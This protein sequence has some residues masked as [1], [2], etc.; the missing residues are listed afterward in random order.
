[1]LSEWYNNGLAEAYI[2]FRQTQPE[3]LEVEEVKDE[4]EK[5]IKDR[6]KFEQFLDE[7]KD[8]PLSNIK[9]QTERY[10][11]GNWGAHQRHVDANSS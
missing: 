6:E 3:S 4:F 8:V 7:N 10:G 1:M 5:L 2:L 9:I 11:K